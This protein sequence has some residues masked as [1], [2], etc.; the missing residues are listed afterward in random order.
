MFRAQICWVLVAAH[1]IEMEGATPEMILN[2]QLAHCEMP[3]SSDAAPPTDTNRGA[4]VG[5]DRQGQGHPEV[6]G[7]GLSAKALSDSLHNTS[8]LSLPR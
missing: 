4:G 8:K 3:D 5:V 2:P 6:C 1:L 7:E